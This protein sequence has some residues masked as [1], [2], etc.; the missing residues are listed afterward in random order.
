MKFTAPLSALI[1]LLAAAPAQ[2]ADAPTTPPICIHE[3]DIRDSS[4][5]DDR[6]IVF[7]LLNGMTYS[8]TLA[9]RCPGLKFHGFAYNGTPNGE[10][11]GNLTTIRVLRAGGTCLLGPFTPHD[12]HSTQ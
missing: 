4:I 5:T 10:L 7:H 11:C 3:R 2:G 1:A 9:A 8:N 6:T 12:D